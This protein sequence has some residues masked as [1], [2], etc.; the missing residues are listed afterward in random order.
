MHPW[1]KFPLQWEANAAKKT[2]CRTYGL[3]LLL[4]LGVESTALES[5]D[6]RGRVRVVGD[7]GAALGAEDA[8]DGLARGA[9]ARPALCGTVHR[10]LILEDDA[11]E[12]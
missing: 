7:R 6:R 3:Q 2:C 12:G 8:V 1:A 4:D 11:D 5:D 10:Q 9:H